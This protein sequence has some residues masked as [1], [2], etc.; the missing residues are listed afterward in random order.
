MEKTVLGFDILP[1]TS[2]NSK[3]GAYFAV[4]LVTKDKKSYNWDKLSKK[5]LIQKIWKY[6]PDYI[7][8]D[9]PFEILNENEEIKDF[10]LNLPKNTVMVQVNVTNN[11][12]IIPLKK[13]ISREL[14]IKVKNKLSP[15]ETAKFIVSLIYNEIGM[16]LEPFE[17]ETIIELSR[18]RSRG[19]GGWSQA[20]YE[21]Q[22]EEV[23]YNSYKKIK[24]ILDNSTVS[25]DE[26]IKKTKFGAKMAR[27]H[28]FQN[29]YG[30]KSI[31]ISKKI[32]YPAKMKIWRPKKQYIEYIPLKNDINISKF[33]KNLSLQILVGIDP[34]MTTA[35]AIIDLN[36]K[37][38]STFSQKN[39]SKS[40]ISD[41]IIRHGTPILIS[42]DVYPV[43]NLVKKIA[44]S[45]NA[46]LYYPKSQLS[47]SMKKKLVETIIHSKINIHESDALSAVI[48][49]Y[50][51]FLPKFNQ[52]DDLKFTTLEKEIARGL[53]IQGI[54][55]TEIKD[56]IKSL[57][58]IPVEQD[59]VD[60]VK[61]D[62]T[63]KFLLK[64]YYAMTEEISKKHQT[65]S[66]LLM[67]SSRQDFI[68]KNQNRLIEKLKNQLKDAKS[69]QISDIMREEIIQN[70]ELEIISLRKQLYNN[71]KEI[72]NLTKRISQLE[73]LLWQTID[74]EGFPIKVIDNLKIDELIYV[75][76]TIGIKSN[77][78]LFCLNTTGVG[79]KAINYLIKKQIKFLFTNTKLSKEYS[80]LLIKSN[81]PHLQSTKYD[82]RVFGKL[83]YIS[84]INYNIALND[85]NK[86]AI[87]MITEEK[88]EKI[89]RVIKNYRFQRKKELEDLIP[90]YDD[91]EL[92]EDF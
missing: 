82:L 73:S 3:K 85:Y 52:I 36:K 92:D 89:E 14:D 47:K 46:R 84:T 38:I 50:N 39:L 71:K 1:I 72:N 67:H 19:K 22:G 23:I 24:E 75:D 48:Y 58:E 7:G 42:S 8:T 20:R 44:A 78:I 74:M 60:D 15:L 16:I 83:A 87:D 31:N 17:N 64:K 86:Y 80:K 61:I 12:E 66:N 63:E 2:P 51:Q 77:D 70:K 33:H 26:I 21:R 6:K 4:H 53:I 88:W 18:P 55:I 28:I 40:E 13:I 43:P 62:Q 37:L 27:F 30:N 49:A 5:Q 76:K 56:I 9:N 34:G 69:S 41:F 65:I 90:N 45:F 29:I 91:F 35:V 68:I 11:G 59:I 25:Y 79:K 57:N 54:S 10:Y 81:I 32:V